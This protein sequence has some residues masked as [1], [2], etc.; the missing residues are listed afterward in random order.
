MEDSPTV[1]PDRRAMLRCVVLGAAIRCTYV[2]F[3]WGHKLKL[4]DSWYYSEQA[5][6]LAHGRWFREIFYDQPGAEH[7]PLTSLLMAPVSFTSHYQDFQRLVTVVT[8]I[9]LVWAIGRFAEEVAGPKVGLVAAFIAAV[10]PNLWMNDGL[11][12]SESISMLLVALSLWAAW[13][14]SEHAHVRGVVLGIALGL[15]VLARSELALLL[16]LV[17]LWLALSR[18]RAALTALGCAVLVVTPWVGFN[19]ARFERPVLLTTNDGTTLLGANCPQTYSGDHLG[20]WL[21]TCVAADPAFSPTEE[22]S[23][24]SARQ[25]SLAVRYALDHM[26]RWPAV[27][28]ARVGRTLDLFGIEDSIFQ[29][30]GEERPVFFA[31]VGV[32]F[33]W[34][35]ALAS[36]FGARVVARRLRWLL[37]VPIVTVMATTVLFYGAH[38]IRST[39]EPVL[40]IL[41]SAAV[42]RWANPQRE[43]AGE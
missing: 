5:R 42:V 3:H 43:P 17:L 25:R 20:G 26:D 18:R 12:M 10:Y 1:T 9:A 37:A 39:A 23:V 38:R 15:A 27:V 22:P 2:A 31:W 36:V 13:R 29:D 33:F 34:A 30:Q 28:A 19:M 16:P 24:R 14:A 4:N 35:I 6:Q 32:V 41:A 11:V 7:G 40:V 8:G 21:V